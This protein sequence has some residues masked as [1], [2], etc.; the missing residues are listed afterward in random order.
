MN[1]RI[2]AIGAFVGASVLIAI[3]VIIAF[4]LVMNLFN[5]ISPHPSYHYI[6][7]G[8]PPHIWDVVPKHKPVK[9]VATAIP[10]HLNFTDAVKRNFS[11]P[12]ETTKQFNL[13]IKNV[14]NTSLNL[15]LLFYNPLTA[16]S[17][18]RYAKDFI[19]YIKLITVMVGDITWRIY[20]LDDEYHAEHYLDMPLKIPPN[21]QVNLTVSITL[22]KAPAGEIRDGQHFDCY[23]YLYQPDSGHVD[24]I[25]FYMDT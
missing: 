9:I 17:G 24:K 16:E 15:V 10:E 2:K 22:G 12:H 8:D 1:N 7:R 13:T 4:I 14:D 3:D 11:V 18:L 5:C 6:E 19:G 25:H 20:Y 21:T 23:L